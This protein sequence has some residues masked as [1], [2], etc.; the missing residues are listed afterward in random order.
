M[1]VWGGGEGENAFI[2]I[3]GIVD[4]ATGAYSL[5]DAQRA[6]AWPGD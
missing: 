4:D 2:Y 3:Y 5:R 1:K 6:R